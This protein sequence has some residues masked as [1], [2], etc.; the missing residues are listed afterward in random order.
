MSESGMRSEIVSRL[1]CFSRDELT[2]LWYLDVYSPHLL[3]LAVLI[4]GG[5][6]MFSLDSSLSRSV[7]SI[8]TLLYFC[9]AFSCF[10]SSLTCPFSRMISFFYSIS[11]VLFCFL[12]LS[13]SSWYDD[14]CC[15]SC[16]LSKAFSFFNS[17][18]TLMKAWMLFWPS[19]KL[20]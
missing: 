9:N 4:E 6:V 8:V 17:S 19:I 18:K 3:D 10:L 5:T 7:V 1:V 14:F 20:I 2:L 15:Y 16:A 12:F 11:L 13:Y